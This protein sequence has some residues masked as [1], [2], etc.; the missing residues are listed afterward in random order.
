MR[1]FCARGVPDFPEI[2]QNFRTVFAQNLRHLVAGLAR[3]LAFERMP[4]LKRAAMKICGLC[5]HDGR[6]HA[7]CSAPFNVALIVKKLVRT[8]DGLLNR[9]FARAPFTQ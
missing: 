2:L 4:T 9:R 6:V 5:N 7:T 8:F 3:Y 1:Y